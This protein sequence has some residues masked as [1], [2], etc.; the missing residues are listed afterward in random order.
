MAR[1]KAVDMCPG[2]AKKLLKINIS[3]VHRLWCYKECAG[4]SNEFLKF[5]EEQKKNIAYLC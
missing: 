5:L 1:V 4:I 3:P 2:C